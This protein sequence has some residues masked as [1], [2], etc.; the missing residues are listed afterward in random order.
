[1]KGILIFFIL[2]SNFNKMGLVYVFE[3]GI[4]F[5]RIFDKYMLMDGYFKIYKGLF[6]NSL[7]SFCDSFCWVGL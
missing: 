1:M 7:L 5:V 2:L 6:L 3:I 4:L